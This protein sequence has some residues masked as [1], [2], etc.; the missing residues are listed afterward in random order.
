MRQIKN[1]SRH[2]HKLD[3]ILND[4]SSNHPNHIAIDT[5]DVEHRNKWN[6]HSLNYQQIT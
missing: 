1:D 5:K 2:F 6:L 4:L 3:I